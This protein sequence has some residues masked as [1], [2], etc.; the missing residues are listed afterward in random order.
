MKKPMFLLPLLG[1]IGVL[2]CVV[3]FLFAPELFSSLP[4]ISRQILLHVMFQLGVIATATFF[5][6]SKNSEIKQGEIYIS[7][8]LAEALGCILSL[9][10]CFYWYG[11]SDV[12]VRFFAI[13]FF[14][15]MAMADSF[16]VYAFYK[17]HLTI[18][19]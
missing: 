5:I 12:M 3:V 8:F 16:G 19:I 4:E 11:V 10:A 6:F 9:L 13:E 18:R 1:L 15:A 2:S 17:K 14:L 7:L